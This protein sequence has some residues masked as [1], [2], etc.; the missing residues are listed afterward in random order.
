[1]AVLWAGEKGDARGNKMVGERV[2]MTAIF[3]AVAMVAYSEL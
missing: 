1:M 2:D 3:S